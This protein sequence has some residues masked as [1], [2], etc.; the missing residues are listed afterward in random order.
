MK[1]GLNVAS[2]LLFAL[3]ILSVWLGHRIRWSE[4]LPGDRGFVA[5]HALFYFAVSCMCVAFG[6]AIWNAL[7]IRG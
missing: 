1:W 4:K 7:F 5:Y 2:A 6:L 3:S